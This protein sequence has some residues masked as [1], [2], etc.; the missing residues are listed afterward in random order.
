MG[1][2]MSGTYLDLVHGGRSN[3]PMGFDIGFDDFSCRYDFKYRQQRR[4]IEL[5]KFDLFEHR[6]NIVH[7]LEKKISF[8]LSLLGDD[9]EALLGGTC[10][11]RPVMRSLMPSVRVQSHAAF[12]TR[13]RFRRN[14]NEAN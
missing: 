13:L 2:L 10:K 6:K 3:T 11:R 9:A 1:S 12:A 8:D 7:F 5:V 4:E 14:S